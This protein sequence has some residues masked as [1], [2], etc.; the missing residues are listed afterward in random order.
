M[1]NFSNTDPFI[2]KHV[3]EKNHSRPTNRNTHLPP[4][5]RQHKPTT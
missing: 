2:N 3:K 5:K 4:K 1:K